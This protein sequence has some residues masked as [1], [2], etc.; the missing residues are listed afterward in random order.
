[1]SFGMV[2][3]MML[4]A[5]TPVI[6]AGD[7]DQISVEEVFQRMIVC[8]DYKAGKIS[9]QAIINV[10]G[11]DTQRKRRDFEMQCVVMEAALRIGYKMAVEDFRKSS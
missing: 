5:S 8:S 1:M 2:S 9:P 4:A 11:L 6:V 10:Y 7:Y 3:A